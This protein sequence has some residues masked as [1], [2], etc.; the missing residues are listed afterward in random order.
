MSKIEVNTIETASGSTLTIGKSGDTVTLASGADQSGF[1]DVQWQSVKTSDFTAAAGEGY[2]I[3]TTSSAVT[4]TLPASPSQGDTVQIRDYAGTF[5]T[6]NVTIN[7]NSEK[8]GGTTDNGTLATNNT[9]VILVYVDSTRGWLTTE[10]EEKTASL[11]PNATFTAATGGTEST[12]GDYKI[13]TFNSSGNFVVSAIGNATIN[14]SGGPAKVSYVVVAGGGAGGGYGGGG[15]G[16]YREG[17]V[18][19]DPYAPAKSPLA[20]PDG[21][22]V[23]LQTYPVT[24]GAGATGN[25]PSGN[26]DGG[27]GLSGSNSIF[28]TITSAGGGGGNAGAHPTQPGAGGSGGGGGHSTTG[29]SGNTPPVS[30]PQGNNGGAGGSGGGAPAP[31]FLGGGGG[32]AGAVGSTATPSHANGGDGVSSSITGSATTRAGGGGGGGY[33]PLPDT[34]PQGGAGNHPGGGGGYAGPG[35]QTRAGAAGSANLGGGGGAGPPNMQ[36]GSG[37]SGIVIVRYKYQ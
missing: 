28:S 22:A 23:S 24:V 31:N 18:S 11:L 20:A 14:P 3:N 13:H 15:A 16:G 29:G 17:T 5:A 1:K 33:P 2:F 35:G 37:G 12:S 36:S 21:I 32:G 30:P 7:R 34:T 26:D 19:T 4:V 27:K 25:P 6:N 10:N 8:I 9:M